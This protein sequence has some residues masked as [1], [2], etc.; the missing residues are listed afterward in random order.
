MWSFEPNEKTCSRRG[1]YF[2]FRWERYW[3]RG[4]WGRGVGFM[5]IILARCSS[6]GICLFRKIIRE[7]VSLELG[8]WGEV[9]LG[10]PSDA[11]RR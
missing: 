9:A 6:I 5:V 4:P 1:D 7:V 10:C 11:G 2:A 8:P 3:E